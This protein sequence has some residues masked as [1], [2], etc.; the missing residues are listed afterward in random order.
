MNLREQIY[1]DYIRE[2]KEHYEENRAAAELMKEE[3]QHTPLIS[4]GRLIDK[5]LAIQKVYT[6]EDDRRFREIV[7]MTHRI[8][9]KV[10]DRYVADP[11]YR[12]GFGFSEKLEALI[13]ADPGYPD[14]LPMARFDIFYHE[15]TGDFKFCEI[16]TDGTSAMNEDFHLDKLNLRN[17]AHQAICRKY[18][19]RSYELFDSWVETFLE[20]YTHYRKKHPEM[21]LVPTVAI[22]DFLD[23]GNVPEFYEFAARFRQKGIYAQVIDIRA[24]RYEDGRLL[25]PEGYEI[26]GIYRRAV[27]ADVMEAYDSVTALLDAYREGNVFLCGS[28]RTQVAHAKTFFSMLHRKETREILTAEENRFVREHVPYT[29]DFGDEGIDLAEV[30]RNKDK[31]ILKPNDSYGSDSVADGRG[32]SPEEWRKVCEAYYNKGFI[33]QE[34]AEQY[35]TPNV[36]FMFGDGRTWDYINMNGLYSYNGNFAGVFTRQARGTIIASHGSERNVASYLVTE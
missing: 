10:I 23:K 12:K 21:P 19:L 8:C 31:Y 1:A 17:P 22:V 11:E 28:F 16:N 14:E 34:Y 3:L 5:P 15:D 2:L 18:R 27:T 9:S 26:H 24:L 33:C 13:L 4:R 6:R 30:I 36:D 20:L 32:R 35:A 29:C 7:E 25:A